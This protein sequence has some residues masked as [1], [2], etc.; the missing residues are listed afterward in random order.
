MEK[1]SF[2]QNYFDKLEEK[3]AQIINAFNDD[4]KWFTDLHYNAKGSKIDATAK[5][6]KG[7]KVHIEIKQRTGTRYGDFKNFI[8]EFDTIFLD[9]GKLDY[10]SKIMSSGYTLEEKELFVSIF[11]NGDIIIIHDLN[12][13]QQIEWLPNNRLFNPGTEKWEY[14]HRIGL[15]WYNGLVYEKGEDGHYKK[16]DDEEIMRIVDK[17]HKYLKKYNWD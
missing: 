4:L 13:P 10:F 9:T 3:D 8:E 15:Y 7:R 14:E 12:R 5:D 6:K 2:K 17:Q 16:W 1:K 11:N